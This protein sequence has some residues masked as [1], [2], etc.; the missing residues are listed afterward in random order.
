[1]VG[2]NVAAADTVKQMIKEVW[3]KIVAANLRHGYSP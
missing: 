3:R 2:G 1:L